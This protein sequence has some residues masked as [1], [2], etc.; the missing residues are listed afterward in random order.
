VPKLKNVGTGQNLENLGDT[1]NLAVNKTTT[2]AQNYGRRAAHYRN[3]SY[4]N[5]D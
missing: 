5:Y 3:S 1:R 4:G 2:S